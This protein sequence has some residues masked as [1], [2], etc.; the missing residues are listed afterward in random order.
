MQRDVGIQVAKDVSELLLGHNGELQHRVMVCLCT[1]AEPKRSNN[2]IPSD[3][4]GV[5]AKNS[6]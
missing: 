6:F 3:Q 4:E 2:N 5:D 1:E